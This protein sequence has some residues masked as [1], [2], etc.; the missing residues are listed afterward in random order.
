MRSLQLMTNLREL[1][2]KQCGTINSESLNAL[3]RLVN[4]KKLNI[5]DNPHAYSNMLT[6][7]LSSLINLQDLNLRNMCMTDQDIAALKPLMQLKRLNLTNCDQLTQVALNHLAVHS[8]LCALSLSGCTG[9]LSET[10]GALNSLLKLQ[11]LSLDR[12]VV[13][14]E[15]FAQLQPLGEILTSLSLND[16]SQITDLTLEHFKHFTKLQEIAWDR[17]YKTETW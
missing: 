14:D 17:V 13:S 3:S 6:S 15:D 11:E 9:I 4:L 7:K 8:E 2:L 5:A 16:C 10:F 1:D 12:T